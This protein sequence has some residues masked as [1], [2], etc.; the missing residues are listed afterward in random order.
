MSSYI[1]PNTEVEI[2]M[3]K[4]SVAN[5]T[6]IVYSLNSKYDNLKSYIDKR[7]DANPKIYIDLKTKLTQLEEEFAKYTP[8][9]KNREQS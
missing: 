4:K 9:D 3:L 2:A 5:L 1:N 8:E 7:V 6:S